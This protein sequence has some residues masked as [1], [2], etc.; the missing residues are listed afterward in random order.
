MKFTLYNEKILSEI[1]K[2][3]VMHEKGSIIKNFSKYLE[4]FYPKFNYQKS[5]I[6]RRNINIHAANTKTLQVYK[7]LAVDGST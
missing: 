3:D 2:I 1:I 5:F 4:M 7:K 6:N